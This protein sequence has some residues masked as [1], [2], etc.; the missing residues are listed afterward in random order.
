MLISELQRISQLW[1]ERWMAVL[2]ALSPRVHSRVSL[3]EKLIREL[4]ESDALKSHS[5]ADVALLLRRI[6]NSLFKPVHFTSS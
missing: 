5:Q 6:H 4:R 2:T 1:D 3:L